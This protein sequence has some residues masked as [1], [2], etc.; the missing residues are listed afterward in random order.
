MDLQEYVVVW[1][2][3]ATEAL[4]MVGEW[5]P[6]SPAHD[7]QPPRGTP[8]GGVTN[9]SVGHVSKCGGKLHFKQA[10]RDDSSHF[11]YTRANHK[12]VL[13]IGAYAQDKGALLSCVDEA[14]IEEWLNEPPSDHDGHIYPSKHNS[15]SSSSS[16]N[17]TYSLVAFPAKDNYE[18]VLYPLEWVDR[19]HAKSSKHHRWLV[20]LDA[21]AF[22]PTHALNLSHT[23]ADF[24]SLSFYKVFG[25]PTGLGA[26][27]ARKESAILLH[28]VYFGGGAV[29]DATAQDVWRILSPPP[30]GLQDGTVNFLGIAELQF[31]FELL[32]QK[33]GGMQAIHDHVSSLQAWT[34]VQ[35]SAL[36]H[37]SG[38]QLLQIFGKH[39][40][41]ARQSCLF[42]FLVHAPNGSVVPAEEVEL[43]AA[44]AGIHLRTGC[45][46]NPG[47]C[48]LDLG[49]EPQEER[50]AALAHNATRG[51]ITVLRHKRGSKLEPVQLPIG[52]VRA[53]LGALSTFEDV[54]ALVQFMQDTYIDKDPPAA[55]Y[56]ELHGAGGAAGSQASNM[57][58]QEYWNSKCGA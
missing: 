9:S 18:G 35:L 8:S 50:A 30:A 52:S 24:V 11:M 48:L 47:Q 29:D 46:C 21:A 12:S 7:W 4:K 17:V 10:D 2:R 33:L 15:S 28:K 1:T 6:W 38:Q 23:P 31:G 22:L 13:G 43:A 32:L 58:V 55:L 53:S 51:F 19:I 44:A 14:G 42:Q 5:F 20:M 16:N 25:Y 27:I 56:G 41:P 3:S 39:A 37:S 54:Y 34:Y 36:R 26:L 40:T 57:T 45:H 49:I